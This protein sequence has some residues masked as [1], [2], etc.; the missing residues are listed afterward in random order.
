MHNM[1]RF[2]LTLFALFTG[3]APGANIVIMTVADPNNYDAPNTMRDF[4]ENELKPA[5]H[6]VTIVEGDNPRKHHFAG[7]TEAL[8]DADLLVLF[9]RRRFPPKDQM[10]AIRGHLDAGRPLIGIRTANHAFIPKPGEVVDS[11][12]APWPGFTHE[13]LGGENTGYETRGLP[14]VVSIAPGAEGSALLKGV[15]PANIRGHQSLYKVLPLADDATPQLI[16]TA[17]SGGATPPQPVAW[18]RRHGA[19]K[20]RIF[21][22]S[23]GAPED[24]RIADL[25]TLLLNAVKWALADD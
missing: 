1:K 25:R 22:T 12:L 21:Y 8:R 15:N 3:V 18:T 4:A 16:G 5:G 7:L 20:A 19:N 2:L 11:G 10:A 6:R 17:Q 23:L 9:S 13:V 24:M 14:Y